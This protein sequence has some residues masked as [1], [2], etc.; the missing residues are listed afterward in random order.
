MS[1]YKEWMEQESKCIDTLYQEFIL[2]KRNNKIVHCFFEGEDFKYYSARINMY[3]EDYEN[4]EQYEC[5][6]KSNVFQIYNLIKNGTRT[7]EIKLLFFIDRDFDDN[8]YEN[9]EI[10]VTP[11]Y[12]VE[13]FY[14]GDKVMEQFLSSELKIR[15]TSEKLDDKKDFENAMKYYKQEREKFIE[16]T[17][18]L[19]V[20]YSL[21]KRKGITSDGKIYADLKKLKKFNQLE[22]PITIEILKGK[23]ENYQE[24]NEIEFEKEKQRLLRDPLKLF[25]GKYY[26]EFMAKVIHKLCTDESIKEGIF[27]KR[28]R[29]KS[30]IS[31]GNII[32]E[33]SQ[34]AETPNCLKEYLNRR[35]KHPVQKSENLKSAL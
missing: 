7:K 25:R 23:T 26:F 30:S 22:K 28:R 32:S 18:I 31:E 1:S 2:L 16:N 21:Q 20:W 9:K 13:N 10:Y 6:G 24:I 35:L 4:I 27:S 19:N 11:G 15:K 14:I 12:A 3:I 17:T 34:Y 33:L 5:K 8:D 29:C